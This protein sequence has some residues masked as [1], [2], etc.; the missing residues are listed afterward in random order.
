M[1]VLELNLAS[2]PF[3][4]DTMLWVGLLVG[5]LL[6][7]W[8]TWWN[9]QTYSDHRALLDALQESSTSMRA[10]F[11][12]LEQRDER[13]LRQIEETDLSSLWA[14]SDKANEVIRWKSFSWTRLFNRLEQIQPW[15][16]QM[17]SIHPVFRASPVGERGSIED[18]EQV[19]V[20][21][22]G[23]AKNLKEYFKL[24]R[25]LIFDPHFDRVDPTNT[26]TDK[27][28][29]ETVF[30]L[31]FLYDPRVV[32]TEDATVVAD[33]AV[34][35]AEGEAAEP[36]DSGRQVADGAPPETAAEP[37]DELTADPSLQRITRRG[38]RNR[39]DASRTPGA[40]PAAETADE[41]VDLEEQP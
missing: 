3:K 5:L 29:G 13:A 34:D 12:D 25:A 14:R 31:R 23:V 28:T 37:A 15:D 8:A 36:A 17:T 39:A 7:G 35:A 38:R 22:E 9:V 21:V 20:S 24:Q 4:N 2:R 16:I 6:L 10:R 33:A 41:A 40:L 27:N 11:V 32:E 1:Q 19:P 30:R 18:L 26:S